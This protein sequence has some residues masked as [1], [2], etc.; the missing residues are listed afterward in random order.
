MI[1]FGL[2]DKG[3]PLVAECVSSHIQEF[4]ALLLEFCKVLVILAWASGNN[5]AFCSLL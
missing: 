1:E 3:L 4:P 2:S 5:S